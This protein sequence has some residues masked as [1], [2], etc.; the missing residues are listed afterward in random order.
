MTD[1]EL[2]AMELELRRARPARLPDD[3]A[4]RLRAAG[5]PAPVRREPAP[6]AQPA[7]DFAGLLRLSLR[8]LFPATAVA[9]VLAVAVKV[10]LPLATHPANP[11]SGLIAAN[12]AMKADDVKIEARPVSS[13]RCSL[14]SPDIIRAPIG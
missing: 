11:R 4:A 8:W 5:P 14:V 7:L 10:G 1:H 6:L 9:V 13:W 3:F 2:E 12:P